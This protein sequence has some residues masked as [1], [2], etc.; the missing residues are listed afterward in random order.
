MWI[1]AWKFVRMYPSTYHL[2]SFAPIY[3]QAFSPFSKEAH[4]FRVHPHEKCVIRVCEENLSIIGISR[5][6]YKRGAQSSDL[7]KWWVRGKVASAPEQ[8]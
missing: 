6:N 3:N 7:T 1:S 5:F 4:P 2:V 8:D